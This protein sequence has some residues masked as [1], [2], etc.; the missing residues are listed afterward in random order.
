M[1]RWKSIAG[2]LRHGAGRALLRPLT[3][4]ETPA[5]R[6]SLPA[7][8]RILFVRPNF[9]M[10]NLL[11]TT[12]ALTA[13]RRALP[14]A[15]IHLLTTPAYVD[16]LRGHPDLDRAILYDRPMLR[17]PTLLIGLVRRLRSARY[18]LVVDGSQG[19]SLTGAL[20]SRFSGGRW[21][22]TESPSRYERTWDVRVARDPARRHRV[23]RLLGVLEGIGIETGPVRMSIALD[24]S[25]QEWARATCQAWGLPD[26]P[27]V[28][29]NIGRRHDTR[30]ASL[31]RAASGVRGR[32]DRGH[33]S[34]APRGLGR[35]PRRGDL[36]QGKPR[37]LRTTR[38]GGSLP[39]GG[40]WGNRARRRARCRPCDPL[41]RPR[42][43]DPPR[44]DTRVDRMHVR[45][46]V[47]DP[48]HPTK[49]AT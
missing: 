6:L 11:L 38:G 48:A 23:E 14:E 47:S 22:V 5:E 29:L 9:R 37:R 3:V 17:L 26:G 42:R 43:I 33:R 36:P 8:R 25:E 46:D 40:S 20:L 12:P 39:P 13:T 27:V 1:I 34:D 7:V 30:P 44:P 32:R 24:P 21:R 45:R 2:R 19:E 18:D 10:G 4:P 15:E 41:V 28:G 49:D 31:R 35:D 16:L